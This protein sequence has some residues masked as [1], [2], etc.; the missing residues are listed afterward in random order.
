[1]TSAEPGWQLAQL[2]LARLSSP[3]D[4]PQL[5]DF[6]GSLEPVN[7]LADA[8]PGFVWR[9]Q[10]DSGNA[11]A[12]RPWGEDTIVNLSVWES[13]TALRAF[14]FGADHAAVLRR[15]RQ[16]FE[17]YGRPSLVLWWVPS[18]HRPTMQEARDRLDLLTSVGPGADAFTLRES[19]GPPS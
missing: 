5:A 11:T 4:S 3:L 8:A 10:D 14:V 16:W 12:L 2:N 17:P 13:V 9:L 18:G 15:R 6:V 1:V 7:A 19:H